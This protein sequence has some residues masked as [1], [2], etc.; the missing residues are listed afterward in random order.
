[1]LYYMWNKLK[2]IS[3]RKQKMKKS[4]IASQR[5]FNMNSRVVW[6]FSPVERVKPSKKIYNRQRFKKG[7]Y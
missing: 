5:Q 2:Y 4:K 1:M 6:A 7:E 3:E